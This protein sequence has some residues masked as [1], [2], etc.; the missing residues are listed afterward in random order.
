MQIVLEL[1]DT[2]I[3]IPGSRIHRCFEERPRAFRR[4][5]ARSR[6]PL[7]SVLRGSAT[8]CAT[9]PYSTPRWPRPAPRSPSNSRGEIRVRPRGPR[10]LAIA[11]LRESHQAIAET[12]PKRLQLLFEAAPIADTGGI[13]WLP[14]LLRARGSDRSLGAMKGEASHIELQSAMA[15]QTPH[16]PLRPAHEILVGDVQYLAGKHPVPMVHHVEIAAVVAAQ[17]LRGRR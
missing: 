2:E 1:R 6:P 14:H 11:C 15:E 5:C 13:Q 8:A 3:L 16:L 10:R 9:R 4:G 17:T 7:L 12:G